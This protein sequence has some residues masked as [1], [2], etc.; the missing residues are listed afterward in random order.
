M[1]SRSCSTCQTVPTLNLLGSKEVTQIAS[2]AR[3]NFIWPPLAQGGLGCNISFSSL[4]RCVQQ[5]TP[6]EGQRRRARHAWKP[7]AAVLTLQAN[8]RI[9]GRNL[10]LA[11]VS[12]HTQAE[13]APWIIMIML[14][15]TTVSQDQSR[16]QSQRQDQGQQTQLISS[17]LQQ[18][19][20]QDHLAMIAGGYLRETGRLGEW[21]GARSRAGSIDNRTLSVRKS[22]HT[23]MR[24]ARPCPGCDRDKRK[25][26]W[27]GY[28]LKPF[29]RR[30]F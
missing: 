15:I 26:F 11:T 19:Q 27:P 1:A 22:R 14:I 3:N 13:S 2:L 9:F 6:A 20:R 29:A 25:L 16:S 21:K 10:R 8:K 23:E 5:G 30:S 12:T 24:Q 4:T 28:V 18:R 17:G 7:H